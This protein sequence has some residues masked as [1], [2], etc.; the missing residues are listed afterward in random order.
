MRHEQCQRSGGDWLIGM[1][2]LR[3]A[4]I[5]HRIIDGFL[6]LSVAEYGGTR[7]K[8]EFKRLVGWF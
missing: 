1:G 6:R 8:G 5:D 3:R 4:G 7:L 2:D